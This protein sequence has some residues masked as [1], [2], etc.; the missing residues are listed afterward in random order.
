MILLNLTHYSLTRLFVSRTTNVLTELNRNGFKSSSLFNPLKFKVP[1]LEIQH[2][3]HNFKNEEHTNSQ[4]VFTL[5]PWFWSW[6]LQAQPSVRS[7]LRALPGLSAEEQT[8]ES[9]EEAG[10]APRSAGEDLSVQDQ[11]C[12]SSSSSAAPGASSLPHT[13]TD[14]NQSHQEGRRLPDSERLLI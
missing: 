11:P 8:G 5:I 9:N 10:R 6:F 12:S 14:Q 2:V 13:H 7:C 4:S 1:N 3:S